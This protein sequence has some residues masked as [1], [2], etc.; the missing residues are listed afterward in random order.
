MSQE[1]TSESE[2]RG[3]W[4]E[5]L[6]V[7]GRKKDASTNSEA[8]WDGLHLAKL[9]RSR[10]RP[11]G[12][13]QC[14]LLILWIKNW[15]LELNGDVFKVSQLANDKTKKTQTQVPSVW[16]KGECAMRVCV[17]GRPCQWTVSGVC[18]QCSLLC[19]SLSSALSEFQPL[20]YGQVIMETSHSF[21]N[22]D[23]RE[24]PSGTPCQQ[25]KT[26][27]SYYLSFLLLQKC[28]HSVAARARRGTSQQLGPDGW[29]TACAPGC[30]A[31]L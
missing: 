10:K 3:A 1:N 26:P 17:F 22:G 8:S 31:A 21:K 12:T 27:K 30:M 16:I 15:K 2:I 24:S 7:V 19:S 13:H 29:L 9:I 25:G 6:C 18:F 11:W 4:P 14:S 23:I 5:A 20:T 28:R